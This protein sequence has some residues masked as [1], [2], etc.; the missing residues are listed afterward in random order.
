MKKFILILFV[1]CSIWTNAQT[2]NEHNLTN[3]LALQGYDPV[4]YF[5][6]SKAIQGKEVFSV[7]YNGARYQ[8]SSESHKARFLKNPSQYEPQYGGYCAFGMSNGYKAPIQPEAFTIVNNK[9]YLNYNLKV[10]EQWLKEQ[11]N[12][13]EKADVN[14]KKL[15]K[16]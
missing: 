16:K 10:K 7:E 14:W 5:E 15:I 4:A 1:F 6:N 8:F 2:A 3:G 12:R 9:L 11:T 13:I